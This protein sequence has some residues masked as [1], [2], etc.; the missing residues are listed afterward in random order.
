M[1]VAAVSGAKHRGVVT[2]ETWPLFYAAKYPTSLLPEP[3]WP[4]RLYDRQ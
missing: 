2:Y 4:N 3:W 1:R